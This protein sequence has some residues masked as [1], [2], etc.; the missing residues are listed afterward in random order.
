M[1][2]K[3]NSKYIIDLNVEHKQ[4]NSERKDRRKSVTLGLMMRFL[5]TIPKMQSTK[6]KKWT[7]WTLLTFFL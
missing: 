4:Q 3:M 5:D 2:T 1:K 6:E 7:R